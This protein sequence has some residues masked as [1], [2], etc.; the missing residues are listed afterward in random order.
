MY[1]FN[2]EIAAALKMKAGHQNIIKSIEIG[3]L[4]QIMKSD[5]T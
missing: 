5:E 1:Y 3:I 2:K 4:N